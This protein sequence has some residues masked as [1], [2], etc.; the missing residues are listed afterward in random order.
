MGGPAGRSGPKSEAASLPV[1]E[2]TGKPDQGRQSEHDFSKFHGFF[3]HRWGLSQGWG[4]ELLWA[5][6]ALL[7]PSSVKVFAVRRGFTPASHK[8]SQFEMSKPQKGVYIK[9]VFTELKK[10]PDG[11]AGMI[12]SGEKSGCLARRAFLAFQNLLVVLISLGGHA[13]SAQ[14]QLPTLNQVA[15]QL[16]KHA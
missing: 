15:S 4:N 14:P 9:V 1:K 3:S 2:S 10:L 11:G 8:K 7:A 12:H 16:E 6:D 13:C 5:P